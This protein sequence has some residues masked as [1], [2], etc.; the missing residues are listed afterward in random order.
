MREGEIICSSTQGGGGYGDV[1][2]RPPE[3]VLE[4]VRRG[5]ITAAT[6]RRVYKV[7]FDSKTLKLDQA[8]TERARAGERKARLN[9]GK[10]YKDFVKGWSKLRPHE[11][12]LKYYGTW[13]DAKPNRQVIRI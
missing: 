1:L 7:E 4:D 5:A 13:P 10:P 9:R 11:Q 6:A 2:E 12:A 3:T 8:A